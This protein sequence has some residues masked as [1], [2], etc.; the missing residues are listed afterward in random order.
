MSPKDKTETTHWLPFL[1]DCA[2][3]AERLAQ[4]Y[5]N[6]PSLKVNTKSN[7]TPVTEADLAIE[8]R[9]REISKER[10]PTLPIYAE[11]FGQCPK[12]SP[13]KLIIDPIDGTQNFVRN[14]PHVGCLLAIEENQEIVA[15]LVSSLI[16]GNRWW[17]SKN[18]GAYFNH[19]RLQ[20]STINTLKE[21]QV[22]HGSLFGNEAEGSS[23]TLLNLLSKTKRQRGFGDYYAPLYVASGS[24]EFAIDFNLKPWDMAPLKII[25]EEAGGVFTD[26]EGTP[27]I[28]G[29][30]FVISNGILH[31]EILDIIKT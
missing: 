17:A 30:G 10:F 24:A 13:L 26:L 1:H 9:I 31:S 6:N 18:E 8:K 20:V 23:E 25:T 28:Y 19:Q 7:H 4:F 14:I 21:S 11:E 5:F 27:S 3:E 12:D 29:K 2:Q 15:G 22:M 16:D